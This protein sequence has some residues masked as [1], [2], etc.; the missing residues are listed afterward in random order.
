MD[1]HQLLRKLETLEA[2]DLLIF[3]LSRSSARIDVGRTIVGTEL[4]WIVTMDGKSPFIARNAEKVVEYLLT[5]RPI[6]ELAISTKIR[7]DQAD[8]EEIGFLI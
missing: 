3:P 2:D 6:K 8:M 7:V 5:L 1:Q 4:G